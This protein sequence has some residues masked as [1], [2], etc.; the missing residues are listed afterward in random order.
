MKNIF[1]GVTIF[2]ALANCQNEDADKFSTI[3]QNV[4]LLDSSTIET[5]A[6][7]GCTI[8]QSH[9]QI[10]SS[11]QSLQNT[12]RTTP[13]G[14]VGN[15]FSDVNDLESRLA[16]YTE[17]HLD[18]IN[19]MDPGIQFVFENNEVKSIWSDSGEKLSHWPNPLYTNS[20]IIRSDDIAKVYGKLV[21]IQQNPEYAPIFKRI[22][23][24]SKDVSKDYDSNMD[25]SPQWYFAFMIEPSVMESVQL[26]FKEGKL[27]YIRIFHHKYQPPY[28]VI[29]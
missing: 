29:D 6:Y 14:V 20:A 7:L 22:S 28:P 13:L 27:S 15:I 4:H 10:Y 2:L 19:A 9:P 21:Q 11:L 8:G 17:V 25:Y 1:I 5:G 26:H 12:I 23:L 24:F 3:E 18:G 16:L